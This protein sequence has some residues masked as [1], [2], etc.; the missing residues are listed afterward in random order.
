MD[1]LR[2]VE[3]SMADLFKG[4][5]SLSNE[6]KETIAKIWPWLALIGGVVQ[7]LAAW[8]L[9][10]LANL[11]NQLTDVANIYSTYVTGYSVGPSAFDKT[12]LY[13]GILMLVVDAVILL[14][15][16]PLLQKRASKGWH[17]LFLASLI[18]VGYAV[19]QLF[20]YNQ[21]IGS[22]IMSLIGSALAFYLL[23]QV[24]EK[25]SGKHSSA[26]SAK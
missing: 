19:V 7:L 3:N 4:L 23:F 24:R 13:A 20:T 9:W 21:G 1:S 18:N 14:M 16:F 11:A 17:L 26:P 12:L 5:P 22:F 2:K 25:F 15:A 10:R 6:T 8:G